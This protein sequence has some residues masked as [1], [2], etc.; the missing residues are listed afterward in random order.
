MTQPDYA[1]ARSRLTESLQLSR[2]TG[3][4]LGIAR[5]LEAFA[6][7]AAGQGQNARAVR[8]AGA[9]RTLRSAVGAS[10]TSGARLERLLEPA[11]KLLGE[12]AAAALLAEGA[13]MTA[14]EAARYATDPGQEAPP[15]AMPAVA[16]VTRSPAGS[17]L[18]RREREISELIARGLSN[19]AIADELVISPATAARHVAN[20][21]TKLGF[22]SRA[23]VAAWATSRDHRPSRP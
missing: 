20:I 12:P 5:G 1:L 22:S 18:T 10:P 11:R 7:L 19:R 17:V 4:R 8:L 6:Q 13:A 9:A 21:L 16:A 2:A 15:P 23:Q 3:Q 14:D